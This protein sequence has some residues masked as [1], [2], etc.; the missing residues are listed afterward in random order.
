MS[1]FDLG[2]LVEV[3]ESIALQVLS[4]L[5]LNDLLHLS[6]HDLL[7]HHHADVSGHG[8]E[9]GNS[10]VLPVKVCPG[11][12]LR[13]I[14]NSH[15]GPL[16]DAVGV[17]HIRVN[18]AQVA[19]HSSIVNDVGL[20]SRVQEGFSCLGVIDFFLGEACLLQELLHNALHAEEVSL[21]VH[22]EGK[23][24]SLLGQLCQGQS[25]GK[26]NISKLVKPYIFISAVVVCSQGREHA[27]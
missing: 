20:A 22:A 6:Y 15:V 17:R 10:L 2:S 4:A 24:H 1:V 5:V 26:V 7:G 27:V 8:R 14:D 25:L 19:D 12:D 23:L 9:P 11:Y 21:P 16:A 3:E 18:L 13:H